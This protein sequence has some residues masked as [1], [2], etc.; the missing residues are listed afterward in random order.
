[1]PPAPV[2]IPP[3][4]RNVDLGVV[5]GQ[6]RSMPLKH[7]LLSCRVLLNPYLRCDIMSSSADRAQHLIQKLADYILLYQKCSD[8]V[9]PYGRVQ[10]DVIYDE[11]HKEWQSDPSNP[12]VEPPRGDR[13]KIDAHFATCDSICALKPQN[14][15]DSC[16]IDGGWFSICKI[17]KN[18]L[19]CP[20][21]IRL[22]PPPPSSRRYYGGLI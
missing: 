7:C 2:T 21:R 9:R 20:T 22:L 13:A 10:T 16:R 17:I 12:L 8:K 1:M 5:Q 19:T 3:A 15:H 6:F 11:A 18:L 14:T 4:P